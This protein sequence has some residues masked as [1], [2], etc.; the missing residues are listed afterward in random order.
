MLN[1]KTLELKDLE[2]ASEEEN[3]EDESDMILN[4][5]PD[6]SADLISDL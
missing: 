5:I 1:N 6:L 2:Q 3:D 4:N